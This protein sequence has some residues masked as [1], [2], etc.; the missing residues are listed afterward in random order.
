MENAEK[1]NILMVDDEPNNL[2]A[3]ESVLEGLGQNLIR[4]N[5]GKEALRCL[6][7]EDVAV[8]LLDVQMPEMDGFETAAMIRS[9]EKSRYTPIIFLT[10]VGKTEAEM[11]R[12]YAVGAVDYMLKPFAPE[13]LRYKVTVLIELHQKSEQVRHLNRELQQL[14]ESL[15]GRIKER[16]ATLEEKSL[17]LVRSNQELTQFASVASH[18]LQEPLRTMSTHLQLLEQNSAGKIDGQDREYMHVVLDSAK[19][20]RQM[21]NDLLSFSQ[22]G[23]GE[24][25]PEKVDCGILID[26]LLAQLKDVVRERGAKITVGPMPVLAAEPLLLS[27]VFQNL[28]LN[29]LKFCKDQEPRIEL[30]AEA[31]QGEWTFWIKDHGI[32]ISPEYFEKIFQLFK[33]LHTRDQYSGNGLGLSICKKIVE[34]HGGKIW[35]ES[36]PGKGSTFYFTIPSKG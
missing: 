16:T 11:F 27:Q 36:T 12:G 30:G 13:I 33:R 23:K 9:R 17:E 7:R 4:A 1:F 24:R 10:A 22:V 14:N 29:A 31:K 15:E 18:D 35:L 34:R 3:L 28:I 19:R 26:R 8:I 21:I 25:R 5:S 6:M 2:L 32:G 20:M